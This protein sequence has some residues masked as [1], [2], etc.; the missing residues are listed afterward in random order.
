MTVSPDQQLMRYQAQARSPVTAYLM[1]AV[2]G[3]LGVHRFYVDREGTG[4]AQL[5]LTLTLVGLPVTL[6]WVLVDAFLLHRYITE[7]NLDLVQ[8]LSTAEQPLNV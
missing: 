1:L 6:V 7:W 8:R 2:F 3:V 5:V 4:I